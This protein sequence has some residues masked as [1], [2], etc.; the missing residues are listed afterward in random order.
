MRITLEEIT[1]LIKNSEALKKDSKQMDFWLEKAKEMN[2]DQMQKL[3]EILKTESSVII[4]T[5]KSHEEKLQKI[6]DDYLQS[7]KSF[8][9]NWVKT[10]KKAEEVI[11]SEENPENILK[12]L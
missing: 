10:M 8:S 2:E 6:N 9:S 1:F 7:L 12:D 4:D 5:K 11:R 3:S